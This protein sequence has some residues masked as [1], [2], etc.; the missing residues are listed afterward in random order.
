MSR[1]GENY[2]FAII[3]RVNRRN[4]ILVG[5]ALG[6]AVLIL[7]FFTNPD[8]AAHVKGDERGRCTPEIRQRFSSHGAAAARSLV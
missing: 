2:C 5:I 8:R 3:W 7:A 1:F 6:V 4:L